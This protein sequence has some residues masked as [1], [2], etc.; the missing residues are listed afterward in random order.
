LIREA[1]ASTGVAGP[2]LSVLRIELVPISP[3]SGTN[4]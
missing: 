1:L 3:L 4:P 2:G